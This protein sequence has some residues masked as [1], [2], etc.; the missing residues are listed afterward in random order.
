[1]FKVLVIVFRV[2]KGTVPIYL[3]SMFTHAQGSYRLR[4]SVGIK[5]RVPRHRTKIAD[6]SL[7]VV[8]P[9]WWNVLPGHLKSAD[10]ETTFKSKLKT[11]LFERFHNT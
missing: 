7:A 5:F 11:Y 2:V 10:S 9:K 4:S 8:G 6:R 3:Q 1:M